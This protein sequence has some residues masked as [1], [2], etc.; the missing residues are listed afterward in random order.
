MGGTVK[1]D[2]G[3]KKR[4][5]RKERKYSIDGTKARRER[6]EGQDRGNKG[7][8][9]GKGSPVYVERRKIAI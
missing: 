1:A 5:D 9:G 6:S 8:T 2:R 3:N 4:T 7:R